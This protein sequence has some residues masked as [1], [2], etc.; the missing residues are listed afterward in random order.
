[1]IAIDKQTSINKIKLATVRRFGDRTDRKLKRTINEKSID[2]AK[3]VLDDKLT[4]IETNAIAA[5]R[6]GEIK[7]LVGSI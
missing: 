7:N 3:Y 6:S 2:P 5:Y 4:A 1:V